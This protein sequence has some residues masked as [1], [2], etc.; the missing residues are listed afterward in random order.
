MKDLKDK[1]IAVVGVST[2][3]TKFGYRIFHDMRAAGYRVDGVNPAGGTV[4]DIP[5]F[6]KLADIPERPDVVITVV[7]PSVT[8]RIVEECRQLGIPELWM[9][10]GSE[11]ET[12]IRAAKEYGLTVTHNACIMVSSAIW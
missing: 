7:P 6:R 10:P 5:I 2:K 8:E 12:A 11:S 4:D 9:Q 1:H 3:T